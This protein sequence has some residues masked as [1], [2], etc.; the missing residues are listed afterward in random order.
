MSFDLASSLWREKAAVIHSH[1]LGRIGGIA[2]T[3]ARRRG[4][5]FVVS[6]H[7]G[8]LDLPGKVREEFNAPCAHGWEWGRL[9]GWL[10]GA[11]HLFRDADAIITCNGNE[12]AL[13]RK[14]HPEKRVVVQPHGVPLELYRK[15][16]RETARAAFPEIFGR[17]TLLCVGRIDPIKNQHWLLDQAQT[18]FQ[19]H[20]RAVLVLAGACTDEPYG[21]LIARKIEELGLRDRVLMTG[22]LPPNDP[23]LIGLLQEASAV[24][25]PSV[26]ETFGLVVLEAW[27]AGSV[28]L[29]SRTSGPSALVRH[30]ENGW[31]F[32]LDKPQEF[33]GALN[34]ALTDAPLARSMAGRGARVS[35]EYGLGALAGRLKNLY[36][37][38]IEEKRCDT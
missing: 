37:Q 31:L 36:E 8:V 16:H 1:V 30:G 34:V 6:I 17:Q 20:P 14:N 32:S 18:I 7:G 21:E 10:V 22:G 27:A 28:V 38:L 35:E 5:P 12:A 13:L 24:V 9:F 2:R 29:S 19:K 4:V 3:V 25:L 11:R 23:R 26:S 33:H 15:D